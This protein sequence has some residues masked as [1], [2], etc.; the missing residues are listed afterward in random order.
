ME[1][2]DFASFFAE[3]KKNRLSREGRGRDRLSL[4]YRSFMFGKFPPPACPGLYY[5]IKKGKKNKGIEKSE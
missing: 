3:K 5:L 4:N 1:Y 2:K